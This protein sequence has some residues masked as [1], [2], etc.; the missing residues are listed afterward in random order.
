MKKM[1][2]KNNFLVLICAFLLLLGFASNVHASKVG[3]SNEQAQAW[4]QMK[5]ENH[6]LWQRLKN[7]ADSTIYA[8]DGLRDG[9]VYLITGD[10]SYAQ[11]AYNTVS[12]WAGRTKSG[13]EPATRN[14]TRINF[15]HMS[16]LYSWISDE[17]SY[18]NKAN[19]RDILDHWADLC[20][21]IE[22]TPYGTRTSDSDELVGHYFGVVLYALAIENEDPA[23]SQELLNFGGSNNPNEAVKPLGGIDSTY[24]GK[25]GYSTWRNAIAMYSDRSLGGQWI[26]SSQYNLFTVR[27]LL[28][29]SKAVN[30][31]K[32]LHQLWENMQR[33]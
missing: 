15:G 28:D 2:Y 31:Y 19:F 7:E 27:M 3:W 12:Y 5:N 1:T 9:M 13:Q 20:F 8:D 18:Q 10:S 32:G 14:D 24:N 23:R 4:Q 21:N 22:G 30:D 29:F 26:E 33:D 25:N 17:L 16:L 6:P 11:S